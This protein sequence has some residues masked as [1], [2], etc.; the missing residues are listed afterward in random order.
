MLGRSSSKRHPSTSSSTTSS[1]SNNNNTEH[2]A[3]GGM[4][5]A[6]TAGTNVQVSR[7]DTLHNK[8]KLEEWDFL[9]NPGAFM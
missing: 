3:M 5:G 4:V 1:G 9:L 2:A 6:N 8:D 7:K